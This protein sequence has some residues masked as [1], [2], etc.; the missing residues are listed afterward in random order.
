MHQR[1]FLYTDLHFGKREVLLLWP[2]FCLSTV[3]FSREAWNQG[4]LPNEYQPVL[5]PGPRGSDK[6]LM[7]IAA[8]PHAPHGGQW[9]PGCDLEQSGRGWG[10]WA[11][12][13]SSLQR[14]QSWCRAGLAVGCLW[15]PLPPNQSKQS[16]A[17]PSLEG[18]LGCLVFEDTCLTQIAR[19]S[20]IAKCAGHVNKCIKMFSLPPDWKKIKNLKGNKLRR[21]FSPV[22]PKSMTFQV[23]CHSLNPRIVL[24]SVGYGV[25]EN[26]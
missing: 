3:T 20:H 23:C 5:G 14:P 24:Q 2:I 4:V 15:Q 22:I 17:Q 10:D 16:L 7:K 18:L 21:F 8:S 6:E 26:L 19:I 1:L 12:Q 13:P 25:L 9:I 11:R